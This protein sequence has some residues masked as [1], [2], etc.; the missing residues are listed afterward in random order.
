MSKLLTDPEIM[1]LIIFGLAG[2]CAVLM[3][4]V[5]VLAVRRNIYYVDENGEE[6]IP[7]S[8]KEMKR[9]REAVKNGTA[10][11]APKPAA[12]PEPV[13]EPAAP[14]EIQQTMVVPV[15]PPVQ[16]EESA[17]PEEP[18]IQEFVREV[19]VEVDGPAAKGVRIL[20]KVG[21]R[22]AEYA[23]DHLPC[24]IGRESGTCDLTISEPAI[25]RRHA[26]LALADN[27]VFIEDVS[28]HNGTFLN[29]T[30]LPSLGS[31]QIHEGDKISLGRAE[32][33][34]LG[35]IYDDPSA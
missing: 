7:V 2:V 34:V 19:P 6:I 11:P 16:P 14:E 8:K 22:E 35:F 26:R 30:K 10:E 4:A 17:V 20:V 33:I 5:L 31:A 24:L 23:V 1:K 25:S 13:S 9:R 18:V 28:E 29:G 12:E 27:K 15:Q 21:N 32:I 3:L